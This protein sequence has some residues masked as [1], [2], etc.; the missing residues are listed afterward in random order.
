[1]V[2]SGRPGAGDE[3]FEAEAHRQPRDDREFLN[4]LIDTTP[5]CIKVVGCDGRLLRM[6]AAGLDM[7]EAPDWQTAC[8]T[9]LMALIAPEHRAVWRENHE[10]VCKGE[11]LAWT[12]DIIGFKGTRRH[13]ETHAAPIALDD[14][15][16]G[17]LAITRDVTARTMAERDLQR[18]NDLLERRVRQRSDELAAVLGRLSDSERRFELLVRSVTDYAIYMLDPTGRVISWNA[19]AERIKG[20]SAQ[21]IIGQ[22]FSRFYTEKDRKSHLPQRGLN[23]ATREGRF[24]AEGWRVRKDGS[25]FWASVVIDAIYDRG[26]I[27]GFAKVTKDIT[28]RRNAEARLRQSQKM[29]AIGQFTGGAAHDFNNLLMAILGSLELLRKR[30]PDD[31]RMLALADNAILAAKRGALLTQRMLAFARRQELKQE[32]VDIAALVSGMRDLIEQS[33]GPAVSLVSRFPPRLPPVL[34]DLSQLETA[35]LNL[36]LNA[37]DAMPKGGTITI[38]AHQESIGVDH[39]TGLH[40]GVY[41]CLQVGDTGHGMDEATLARVTEP[42]FTTKDIGKGT[43]LGLSM[44]DGLVAQS[45]G[46]L[47]I[48]SRLGEGTTV[49]LWLPVAEDGPA[50]GADGARSD[51]TQTASA[52]NQ[53]VI[54]AVDD[55]SLVLMNTVAMLED[56]GHKVRDAISAEEALAIIDTDPSIDLVISDQGM[57]KMTGVQMSAV[58]GQRRPGLPVIIVTGYADLPEGSTGFAG[59]LAKPFSQQDLARAVAAITR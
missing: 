41:C 21:E 47:Q 27:I 57:P 20:Y 1:M 23:T 10:R 22:D 16:V 32:P 12:F 49:R 37:R 56:M 43:G 36:A 34:S 14:G 54:L 51:E 33:I 45:G 46:K 31:R 5:E 55:D 7:I 38:S 13:M 26:E 3:P 11:N 59:R 4:T 40:P 24:E 2:Q 58:I 42:F 28:E 9:D 15:T 25:R 19:G 48:E 39:P 50:Q 17:Q 35:I 8:D 44:A 18:A 30:L 6:N 29:E 53:L 52:Q